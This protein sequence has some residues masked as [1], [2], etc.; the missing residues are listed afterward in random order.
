[1]AA[2]KPAAKKSPG[3]KT[4]K[5]KLKKPNL[6]WVAVAGLSVVLLAGAF[7]ILPLLATGA[8]LP[9]GDK[10]QAVTTVDGQ[11]FFGKVKSAGNEYVEIVDGYYLQPAAGDLPN[12]QPDTGKLVMLS[13]RLY[14]PSG[15]IVIAKS[16]ILS[17]EVLDPDGQIVQMMGVGN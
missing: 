17:F 8:T 9:G 12:G 2:S 16:Q 14:G 11:I 4:R 10:Y 3:I 13:N 5:P 1:V 6:K 15:D 7:F